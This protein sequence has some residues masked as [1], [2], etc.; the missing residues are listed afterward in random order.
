MDITVDSFIKIDGQY[1]EQAWS[2]GEVASAQSRVS[3]EPNLPRKRATAESVV[4]S[5]RIVEA[6]LMHSIASAEVFSELSPKERDQLR[7]C[8]VE[9]TFDEADWVF[10]QGEEGDALYV[11]ISGTAETIRTEQGKG[12]VL[13]A[14]MASGDV[15]GS[16]AL[17][18][19]ETR[20][21]SVKA[22]SVMFERLNM[23]ALILDKY[24]N[25]SDGSVVAGE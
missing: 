25:R 19:K 21:A 5:L 7:D 18:R 1:F 16:R 15:F 14:Q 13:L 8:M 9:V 20:Y 12:D 17:L 22:T 23:R 3:S 4:D 24:A 2:A 10:E 11:I 6:R